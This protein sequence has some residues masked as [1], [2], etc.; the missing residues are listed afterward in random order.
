MKYIAVLASGIN[1]CLSNQKLEKDAPRL[2]RLLDHG[3][4]GKLQA[5]TGVSTQDEYISFLPVLGYDP[6]IC[7]KGE[8]SLL[9]ARAGV[10]LEKE[11]VAFCCD[12]VTLKH[13]QEGYTFP[14]FG[15]KIVMESLPPDAFSDEEGKELI[16][17]I[18]AQFGTES[19]VFYPVKNTFHLMVWVGGKSKLQ[20][21]SPNEMVGKPVS[22]YLPKGEGSNTLIRCMEVTSQFLQQHPVNE[23]RMAQ[24]KKPANGIW[25]SRP[26]K[27]M[28]LATWKDLYDLRGTMI[29]DD[30]LIQ[31][32]GQ[33]AGFARVEYAETGSQTFKDRCALKAKAVIK[34]LAGHDFVFVHL[35]IDENEKEGAVHDIDRL[36]LSP[37]LEQLE[38]IEKNTGWRFL[39]MET[40]PFSEFPGPLPP[41]PVE[42]EVSFLISSPG[43][44]KKTGL[45]LQK[46]Y[47]LMPRFI[48]GG[49][50]D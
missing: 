36:F 46:G 28:D 40:A 15:P 5:R 2:K 24:G 27:A 18:N 12:L 23:E 35:R 26:G 16:R 17:E 1:P 33:L 49:P 9:A 6:G 30:D 38:K 3:I 32:V 21:V 42:K 10:H 43:Q 8:G 50:W 7:Y 4:L 47:Q 41:Q 22:S 37:V 11:D 19:I 39:F 29:A 34:S 44:S 25:I 48:N 31:G 45:A 14:K 20:S 13:P